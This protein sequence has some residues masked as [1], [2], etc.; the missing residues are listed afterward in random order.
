MAMGLIKEDNDNAPREIYD[1]LNFNAKEGKFTHHHYDRE[2]EVAVADDYKNEF[3]IIIDFNELKV[4]WA[5][6]TQSPPSVV[7]VPHG[8]SNQLPERPTPDHKEYFNVNI[9]NKNLNTVKFGSSAGSII[10]SF[11]KLHDSYISANEKE[12]LPVIQVKGVVGPTKWG[13]ATVYLPDWSII[14]WVERP[15]AM[16]TTNN[17]NKLTEEVQEKP[18]NKEIEKEINSLSPSIE[19]I[20]DADDDFEED[21]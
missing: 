1:R 17:N 2:N 16:L 3:K 19:D 7:V 14:D 12:K 20:K 6:W 4:G 18:V 11:D 13:K 21:F 10:Q 15:E 9:Y 8:V 5:D